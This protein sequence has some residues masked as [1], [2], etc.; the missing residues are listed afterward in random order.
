RARLRRGAARQPPR[1]RHCAGQA[2]RLDARHAGERSAVLPR[3]LRATARAGPPDRPREYRERRGGARRQDRPDRRRRLHRREP[4][5]ARLAGAG[6][7][8]DSL[9]AVRRAYPG[10]GEHAALARAAD[11]QRARGRGPCDVVREGAGPGKGARVP[12]PGTPAGLLRTGRLR[13]PD[14][15]QRLDHRRDPRFPRRAQCR[16]RG[17]RRPRR[18]PHRAGPDLEPGSH[19][20]H[21]SELLGLGVDRSALALGEGGGGEAR[22]PFAE[23]AVRL[24]RL[25]AGRQPPARHLVG[26]QAALPEGVRPRPARQGRRVPPPVLSPRP[27]RGAARCAPGR[28]RGAAEMSSRTLSYV[29]AG[30]ALVGLTVLAFAVGRYPISLSDMTSLLL[31]QPVGANVETVVL[32]VRGPRVL[33][34]LVVGASLAAAGTAYQGMFRNPLV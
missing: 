28:A 30:G 15:R 1:V 13:T 17:A 7:N 22:L 8:E 12:R 9:R 21:G 10:H 25:P 27:E 20:H 2:G 33:A 29:L 11:G 18:R 23:P 16:R 19:P 3:P 34:A 4:R 31:G 24:V 5:L 14:R 32:Q 26:G 6:A